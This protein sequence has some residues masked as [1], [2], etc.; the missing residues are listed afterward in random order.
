MFLKFKNNKNIY[1][2]NVSVRYDGIVVLKKPIPSD[3]DFQSGFEIVT[4]KDNGEVY[5]VYNDYTTIYRETE[6]S[7]MLSNDGTVWIP[8]VDISP[9]PF[10]EYVPTLE[11]LKEQKVAEMNAKQQL[12]IK[13]GVDVILSDGSIEHF[14]LTEHDQTSLIGL[15]TQ[16][17]QG[18]QNIPWH[19]SD[20]T[21]HCKFYS[22]EDMK[23]IT[24]T[25][26]EYL[27][28][29]ITYFRDLRI[30]IRSLNTKEEVKSIEY[31]VTIPDQYRSDPLK[32][33][34]VASVKE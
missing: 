16:V 14:T 11:E 13:N 18:V 33:M 3:I 27:T 4:C 22:N 15:Q 19:N 17:V 21:E 8:P 31:G 24:S 25:A 29:H 32:A 28:W 20:E 10:P 9:E 5:G 34:I 6:E 26:M 23:L 12:A 1:E 7:I 2:I 30:Y